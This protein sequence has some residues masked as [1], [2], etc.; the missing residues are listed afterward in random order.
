M[1]LDEQ[2]APSLEE[3]LGS[4]TNAY[5]S[6]GR[7]LFKEAVQKG[8]MG[9]AINVFNLSKHELGEYGIR[10]L[11]NTRRSANVIEL[12]KNIAHGSLKVWALETLLVH[13]DQP[14][15]DKVFDKLDFPD[16][17]LTSVASRVDLTCVPDRYVYLLKKITDK[18]KR[19]EAVKGG[20]LAL[21]QGSKTECLD[22]LI[23]ALESTPTWGT[24]VKNIAIRTAFNLAPDH[25][26]N[27]GVWAKRFFD[28]PAVSAV[29]YSHALY[30][31]YKDWTPHNELFYWLVVR[32][33]RQDLE[34]VMRT[35][36]FPG[37]N[38][39]FAKLSIKSTSPPKTEPDTELTK[40]RSRVLKRQLLRVVLNQHK[41]SVSWAS[42]FQSTPSDALPS[43][44]ASID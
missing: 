36:L 11:I 24:A 9:T 17:F 26:I 6:E 42:S 2:A 38:P 29:D 5:N 43:L 20:V 35:S 37:I 12:I 23:S 32:A 22:P 16:S 8:D 27:Q 15:I 3:D 14:L 44:H 34:E 18:A 7:L 31:A 39:S 33:D 13:A 21:F 19:E 10:Y 30:N 40:R 28:H 1:G 4:D 41:F 25:G